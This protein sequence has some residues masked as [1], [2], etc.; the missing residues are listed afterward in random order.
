MVGIIIPILQWTSWG[1]E[2]LNNL[3]QS[4]I[5]SKCQTLDLNPGSLAP[6]LMPLI[7]VPYFLIMFMVW[8]LTLSTLS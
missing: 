1:T 4:Y 3:G 8:L 2:R 5:A 6:E 7:T